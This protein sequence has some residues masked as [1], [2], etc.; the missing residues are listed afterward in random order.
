MALNFVKFI[1]SHH[2]SVAGLWT[3]EAKKT[4]KKIH[5]LQ[6]KRRRFC[7]QERNLLLVLLVFQKCCFCF[8]YFSRFLSRAD[9]IFQNEILRSRLK[10]NSWPPGLNRSAVTRL[11]GLAGRR[12]AVPC[13][14]KP[15]KNVHERWWRGG[16]A[17]PSRRAKSP[18]AGTRSAT[19]RSALHVNMEAK[20]EPSRSVLGPVEPRSTWREDDPL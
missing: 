10:Y 4:N 6:K 2:K 14:G 13:Q 11:F 19:T 12:S 16:A 1:S 17:C 3:Q 7:N 8:T 9:W 18:K 20:C 15:C 5:Q